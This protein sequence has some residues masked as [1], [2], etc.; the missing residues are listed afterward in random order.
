MFKIYKNYFK[1]HYRMSFQN[2]IPI[3]NK[4]I[5]QTIIY[6]LRGIKLYKTSHNANNKY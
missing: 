4:E 6:Q 1:V 5:Y 3:K 2:K